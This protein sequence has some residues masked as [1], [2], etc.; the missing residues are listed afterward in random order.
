MS[1]AV[2]RL[3]R[4]GVDIVNILG[5]REDWISLKI[6]ADDHFR[7]GVLLAAASYFESRICTLVLDYVR[8]MSPET[9]LVGEFV[10]NKAISRQY[11]TWFRWDVSNANSFFGLFGSNFSNYMAERI[12]EAPELEKSIKTFLELGNARNLLVHKDYA[13]FSLDKTLEDIY[14]MYRTANGFVEYLPAALR[15]VK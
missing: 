1:T 13:A 4:E 6:A 11:H 3:Y 7:K 5:S 9:S 2:D 14:E 15:S 10:K 12:K 8:E